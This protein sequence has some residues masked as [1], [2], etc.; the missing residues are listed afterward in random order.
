[1]VQQNKDTHLYKQIKVNDAAK[2]AGREAIPTSIK[3]KQR[4]NS[5]HS[6]P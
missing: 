3:V 6:G 4:A 5:N 1:M 2:M